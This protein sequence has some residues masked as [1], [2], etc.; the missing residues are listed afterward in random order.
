MLRRAALGL[1]GLGA[2]YVGAQA[3]VEWARNS[4]L[5]RLPAMSEQ[6]RIAVV[7]ERAATY[8]ADTAQ[9]E[10]RLGID[11]LRRAAAARAAGDVLEVA[12]GTGRNLSLYS[13]ERVRSVTLVDAAPGMVEQA[14]R[15]AEE[16]RKTPGLVGDIR[17]LQADAAA[18]PLGDASMDTVVD[19]FGLCSFERHAEALGEMER[20]LRPGGSLLLVEHGRAETG[21]LSWLVNKYL[22]V[23][24]PTQV[25]VH[26]AHVC[27]RRRRSC[28]SPRVAQV[29]RWGCYHNR[30][31]LEAVRSLPNVDIVSHETTRNALG[32]VHLIVAR[33]PPAVALPAPAARAG[34]S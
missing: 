1:G 27:G 7:S 13:A 4:R 17:V 32:S 15:R 23:T 31:V 21:P 5:A 24:V 8:D 26:D 20:V 9:D 12:A 10:R 19:M 16:T 33:K 2:V 3:G 11:R 18:L 30:P 25:R 14:R 6:E 22:D 29:R 28:L 34:Q